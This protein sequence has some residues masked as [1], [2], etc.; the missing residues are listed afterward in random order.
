MASG[1]SNYGNSGSGMVEL[2][3]DDDESSLCIFSIRSEDN[4]GR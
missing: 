3:P 2:S 1:E 4:F